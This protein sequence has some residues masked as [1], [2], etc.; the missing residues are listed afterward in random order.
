MFDRVLFVL[1]LALIFA[2]LAHA[3]NPPAGSWE[4]WLVELRKGVREKP[5]TRP[6]GK[7]LSLPLP[8]WVDCHLGWA[9]DRPKS[10]TK[11]PLADEIVLVGTPKLC[12][13]QIEEW[14]VE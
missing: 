7:N 8:L 1:L 14:S 5:P 6:D 11:V 3:K 12:R 2:P 10:K 4:A 13:G 9:M